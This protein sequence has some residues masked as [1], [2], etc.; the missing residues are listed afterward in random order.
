[1]FCRPN[2]AGARV[3]PRSGCTFAFTYEGAF[4]PSFLFAELHLSSAR[5]LRTVAFAIR[6]LCLKH[7][8]VSSQI[9]HWRHFRTRFL[10]LLK[11]KEPKR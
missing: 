2:Q 4:S 7:A 11:L 8:V 6:G 10:D 1:M 9:L 3:L 5:L